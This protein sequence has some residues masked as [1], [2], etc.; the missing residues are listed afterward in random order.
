MSGAG[1]FLFSNTFHG[2]SFA[3]DRH[4]GKS[5]NEVDLQETEVDS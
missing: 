2:E 1:G 5:R 3:D 4:S